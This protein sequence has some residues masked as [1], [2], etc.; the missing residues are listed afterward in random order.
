MLVKPTVVMIVAAILAAGWASAEGTRGGCRGSH[1]QLP[2]HPSHAH[3]AWSR[4]LQGITHDDTNWFVTNIDG[5]YRIPASVDLGM[6][7]GE[8]PPPKGWLEK[9]IPDGLVS[10]GFNH[11]G[12]LSL[13]VH[14]GEGF[15]CVPVERGEPDAVLAFFRASDLEFLG[16]A[17]VPGGRH[18]AAF[19]ALDRGGHAVL[20]DRGSRVF[21][22]YRID[23][24]GVASGQPGPLEA[25]GELRLRLEDGAPFEERHFG[26]AAFSADGGLLYVLTGYL[27]DHWCPVWDLRFWTGAC[28]TDPEIGGIH[29]FVVRDTEGGVCQGPSSCKA[30]RVDRSHN[31]QARGNHAFLYRY[32]GEMLHGEE[33]EGITVWDLD[34]PDAPTPPGIG[35]Q[36]HALMLDNELFS[37][38]D[39]ASLRH[40]RAAECPSIEDAGGSK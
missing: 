19:C 32:R 21:Q 8:A 3:T 39:L 15:L 11:F 30:V 23:W 9:P 33:P 1:S 12:D 6:A 18:E 7:S 37:R 5:L 38:W 26:G 2:E 31:A 34:A 4:D 10:R 14:R 29:V 27:D 24:D 20:A 25:V 17:T 16:T 13:H 28:T 40:Y 35:G 22:R 36:V